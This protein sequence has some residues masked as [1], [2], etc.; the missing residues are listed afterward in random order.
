[1]KL[2]FFFLLAIGHIAIAQTFTV[3]LVDR[4]GT[5]LDSLSVA[6]DLVK[7]NVQS[8]QS[9]SVFQLQKTE[10]TQL[11]GRNRVGSVLSFGSD[12]GL[13]W[14]FASHTLADRYAFNVFIDQVENGQ[15]INTTQKSFVF[16]RTVE[17]R[18][19]QQQ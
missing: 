19:K 8:G 10:V 11:R 16:P 6:P 12:L 17:Q 13:K 15:V 7:V 4:R 2:T 3:S 1:M 18:K 14:W 9:S 5:P